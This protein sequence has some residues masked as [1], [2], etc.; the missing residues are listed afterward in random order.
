MMRKITSVC[1]AK[2]VDKFLG[3]L[4]STHKGKEIPGYL[5][6]RVLHGVHKLQTEIES[7][8]LS[9]ER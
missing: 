2:A 3:I 7:I 4:N 6:A 1:I 9:I 5:A 8:Y